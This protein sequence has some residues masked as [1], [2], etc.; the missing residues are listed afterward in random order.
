MFFILSKLLYFFIT[1]V[2]WFLTGLLWTL[3]AIYRRKP[4][5]V[6]IMFSLFVFLF[7]TNQAL[8]SFVASKWEVPSLPPDS[9]AGSYKYG[10]VLGGMA[11]LNPD[12]GKLHVSGSIDRLLTA[13]ILYKQQKIEKIVITSGSG[14]LLMNE[15][16]EAPE[17]L[18]FCLQMGVSGNDIILE[19]QSRNT[20]ENA[21]FTKPLIE[22]DEK[23][24]LI[25][26]AFHM[27]RSAACFAKLG[28]KF[29]VIS[30]D[31][32]KR[33]VLSADDYFLPKA[34]PVMQWTFFI[35][36]WIGFIAYRFAGYI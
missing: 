15:K 32:I 25:T 13:I 24:L 29:D 6:A 36:E 11:S 8:V 1:P 22:N 2:A 3:L 18:H 12:N 28:Y 7:F 9:V 34:E 5:K 33:S 30:T 35:K 4:A 27:R 23:V 21:L 10:I 19:D 16:K 20:H 14:S 26:S 31:P 17:L